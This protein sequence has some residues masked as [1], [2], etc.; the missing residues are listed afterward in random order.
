MGS[1]KLFRLVSR[2]HYIENLR[3]STSI[4]KFKREILG[5]EIV[6]TVLLSQS[7][8]IVPWIQILESC[9]RGLK[10]NGSRFMHYNITQTETLNSIYCPL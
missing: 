9:S 2:L 1:K 5:N 10:R 3:I 6:L 4:L 7:S 8:C